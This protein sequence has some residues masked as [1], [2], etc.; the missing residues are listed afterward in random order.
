M[1]LPRPSSSGKLGA[2]TR[3]TT[4][5]DDITVSMNLSCVYCEIHCAG[6]IV[7]MTLIKVNG[8]KRRES[9]KRKLI[10]R[11]GLLYFAYYNQLLQC[12]W[13]LLYQHNRFHDT[14]NEIV[15]CI[16]SIVAKLSRYETSNAKILSTVSKSLFVLELK[17]IY[18]MHDRILTLIAY[19]RWH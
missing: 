11:K 3:G 16:D 14:W 12:I 6:I 10:R 17:S 9:L 7:L 5:T 15:L 1:N 13:T 4:E 19:A 2:W 8:R 18:I